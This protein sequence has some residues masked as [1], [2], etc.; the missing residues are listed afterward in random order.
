[1]ISVWKVKESNFSSPPVFHHYGPAIVHSARQLRVVIVQLIRAKWRV[2]KRFQWMLQLKLWLRLRLGLMHCIAAS[3]RLRVRMSNGF[4]FFLLFFFLA[5]L[6]IWLVICQ[7]VS[8][9]CVLF[10][11][12]LIFCSMD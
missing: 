8:W 12:Q 10:A 5:C 6:C 2:G 9:T 11:F 4:P 7:F 1:M 3:C